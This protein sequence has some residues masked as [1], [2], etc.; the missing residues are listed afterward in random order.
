MSKEDGTTN[1]TRQEIAKNLLEALPE[2]SAKQANELTDSIIETMQKTLALGQE[3][4]I[5]GFGKFV[6]K[7]KKE[8]TGRNPQTGDPVSIAARRVL[9][10]KASER[11]KERINAIG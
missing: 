8:R 3:V 4:K 9:K 1:V 10:F 5:S 6:V 2:L 11:L 7:E